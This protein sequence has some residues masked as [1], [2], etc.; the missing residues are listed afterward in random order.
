M[1]MHANNQRMC[2]MAH[3]AHTD[4]ITTAMLINMLL[5]LLLCSKNSASHCSVQYKTQ[6]G[7]MH[8]LHHKCLQHHL[9]THRILLR[10]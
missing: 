4:S 1:G 10:H 6:C 3:T 9:S 7:S 8:T 2:A 5:H